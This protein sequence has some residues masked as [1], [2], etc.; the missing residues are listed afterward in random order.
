MPFMMTCTNSG[1]GKTQPPYIDKDTN[2]VYCSACDQIIQNVTIFAKTQMK[3]LKQYRQKEK[4]SFAVKCEK[5][6]K[7]ERPK[8]I[9]DDI[10]C[11]A[12]TTPLDNLSPFFKNML[13][14]QL[15]KADKEL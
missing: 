10:V 14:T 8:I 9:G 11:G 12:C 2:E 13:K 15:A 5:C 1:C 3:T 4:K 7:E 6:G